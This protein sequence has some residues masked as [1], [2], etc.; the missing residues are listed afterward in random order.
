MTTKPRKAGVRLFT[1]HVEWRRGGPAAVELTLNR[2]QYPPDGQ[3]PFQP[4]RL[5]DRA[6]LQLQGPL[7]RAVRRGQVE[8]TLRMK[9]GSYAFPLSDGPPVQVEVQS[10]CEAAGNASIGC[11]QALNDRGD[12]R[13]E[14]LDL[15]LS[16]P[17]VIRNVLT[18]LGQIQRTFA[19]RGLAPL[20]QV[21]ES[22][23]LPF[24]P[25]WIAPIVHLAMGS[26]DGT[27][28]IYLERVTA[29]P[30]PGISPTL[31]L[32][33]SG[34]VRWMDQVETRFRDVV[35][36]RQILPEPHALLE[37]LLSPDPLASAEVVDGAWDGLGFARVAITTAEAA[38]LE[39]TLSVAPPPVRVM[40]RTIDGTE[41]SAQIDP[42]DEPVVVSGKLAATVEGHR[43]ALTRGDL[44]LR[45]SGDHEHQVRCQLSGEAQL[46]LDAPGLS[47]EQRVDVEGE[48]RVDAG[49]GSWPE[50]RALL[51]SEE[52]TSIGG[53]HLLAALSE[54]AFSGAAS[55]S[56]GPDRLDLALTSPLL[57]YGRLTTAEPA[58]ITD[59]RGELSLELDAAVEGA[60]RPAASDEWLLTA[61][62]S[63]HASGRVLSRV[64]SLP[65]LDINN[66]VLTGRL[67]GDLRAGLRANVSFPP[68]LGPVVDFSESG[69][70]LDLERAEL[71]LEGRLTALPAGTV[72]TGKVNRGR[73]G[74]TG[75][76]GFALSLG[77]DLAGQPCLLHHRGEAIS[78]LT[79]D[80]RKGDLTLHL[81]SNGKIRFSGD[82][83]GLYGVRYFNALLNPAGDPEHLLEL[84]RS[85]DAQAH[86]L[87]AIGAF[88]PRLAEALEDMR[89]LALGAETIFRREGYREPR[90]VVPRK[91]MAHLMSVMLAGDKRL[92]KKLI[93]IIRRVTDGKG[94]DRRATL[95]LLQREL[96][97][98]DI[99]FELA[100]LVQWLDLVLS[101]TERIPA[102]PPVEALPLCLDP[103]FEEARRG[104]P[105]AAELYAAAEAGELSAE[106]VELLHD[107]C[108][109][110]TRR[111]IDYLL[112]CAAPSWPHALVRRLRHVRGVKLKVESMSEEYGGGEFLFQPILAAAFLP[113]AA[114]P[115]PGFTREE[116][117]GPGGWPPPCALGPEDVAVL[118]QAGLS[119]G[120]ESK[121]AQINNRI[122]LELLRRQ[123]AAFTQA[124]LVEVGA[125]NP[126]ALTG[127]LY[128]FLDQDQDHMAAPVDLV[129]L[130]S[131]KLDMAIPV[132][133]DYMAGGR[134][135]SES[136]YQALCEVAD[137]IIERARPF[138][139]RKQHLQVAR[140]P[141]VPDLILPA[142]LEKLEQQARE[143]IAR[144]DETAAGCTFDNARRGG[145]RA[146]ARQQY[147]VAF[148]ACARLLERAPRAFQLPWLRQF[149]QRNEEALTVL[150]VV[151]GYQEDR[152]HDRRWLHIQCGRDEL[153]DEQGLTDTVIR[154]LYWREE[155]Q[156]A[157]LADPLAR[158][159]M[160][161]EP[162][163]YR[164]SI[165]SCMGVITEGADGRELEHAYRRLE[166]R[167]GV[168]IVRSATATA[169]SLE[170]NCDRI[171]EGISACETPWGIIGYSQGCANALIAESTLLGGP[172]DRRELLEGLVS[173]KLLFS[174]AN[175][176]CHGTSGMLKFQR[177]LVQGEKHLKHYQAVLSWEAIKGML[178]LARAVLDSRAFVHILGGVHSLTYE[179]AREFHRD[180]QFLDRVPTSRT[181]GVVHPDQLPETLEFLYNVLREQTGSLDQDTQVT[182][183]E[184]A[185]SSLWVKNEY[186]RTLERCDMGSLVQDTHH[187]APLT[188]EIEM[189]TTERDQSL[190]IYQSPKDRLVWPWVEVNARFGR[191]QR[192]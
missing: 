178:R 151:R 49:E 130:L 70:Q 78:L 91:A 186:T 31:R 179:R 14:A 20:R 32:A 90:H 44:L 168:R 94:L 162:G 96:G 184:A 74:P 136:Y 110:L 60:L 51:V 46:D 190:G 10:G 185:G 134:H 129:A 131:E 89:A 52:T 37:R 27:A 121:R 133:R 169:R 76:A 125:Q 101:P 163:H 23:L 42:P 176:S 82:G 21:V 9:P 64:M 147:R 15:R 117:H 4:L 99:D 156:R 148:R 98:F 1:D 17:L 85:D 145:P 173:R 61:D 103:A 59:A 153:G 138:L 188:H 152:E 135:A 19:D 25:P 139:A 33:F 149:W 158:L 45:P 144:A 108:P 137:R 106:L 123:P 180:E 73:L 97:E 53:V 28:D 150:S 187:W 191:I 13:V 57:F 155:D 181:I 143:R 40:A 22:T 36:P 104:L 165:V 183:H 75:P 111:Q 142:D 66:G 107:I 26:A 81:E 115:L 87:N 38:E 116:K 11:G 7:P 102:P 119:S 12:P 124:V 146:R 18:A 120:L 56:A 172:P 68:N 6:S 86:V 8:F 50:L 166:E 2:S 174:A 177:A 88:A 30:R 171:I 113:E 167:R 175:G 65:E 41:L 72:I 170:Y 63:S 84:L 105:S 114:G 47:P 93:P 127:F 67:A 128:A 161:P 141:Q 55:L 34:R 164:F 154:T 29:R 132:Q 112:R 71:D 192:V 83:S 160:D 100:S 35:L 140:H 189:A 77:W 69:M 79:P 5:P 3:E 54:L 126:R 48:A 109:Q 62:V 80:L 43:L 58:S 122:L 16:A 182:I 95:R 118:I 92:R 24:V 159:L 157:M 39:L